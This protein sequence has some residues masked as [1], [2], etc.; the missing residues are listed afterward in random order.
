M[1]AFGHSTKAVRTC[2]HLNGVEA[3]LAE[4]ARAT[5]CDDKMGVNDP[6]QMETTPTEGRS[7]V[8]GGVAIGA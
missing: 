2:G 5:P 3:T 6:H 7:E 4:G 8:R 1:A